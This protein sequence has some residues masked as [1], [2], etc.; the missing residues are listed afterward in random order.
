V[1]LH[2]PSDPERKQRLLDF[3]QQRFLPEERTEDK[4]TVFGEWLAQNHP[5]LLKRGRCDR[6]Q[7]LT[8]DLDGHVRTRTP[9]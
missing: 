2:K 7:Q 6:R 3:W 5:E 9:E 4:L 8:V 1:R